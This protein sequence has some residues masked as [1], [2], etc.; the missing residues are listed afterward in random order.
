[1]DKRKDLELLMGVFLE[2]DLQHLILNIECYFRV[3]NTRT[4]KYYCFIP[5]FCKYAFRNCK[6]DVVVFKE[7]WVDPREQPVLSRGSKTPYKRGSYRETVEKAKELLR[8]EK[9]ITQVQTHTPQH[10]KNIKLIMK[11]K[12]NYPKTV[13]AVCGEDFKIKQPYTY[14]YGTKIHTSCHPRV[15]N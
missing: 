1:M 3:S 4:R 5:H 8:G 12:S 9:I 14:F 2:E 13:C 15:A 10:I 7:Y 6:N 11:E